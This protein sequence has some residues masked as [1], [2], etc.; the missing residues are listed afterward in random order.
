MSAL[1]PFNPQYGKS[2]SL[3][4]GTSSASV[5]LP[6]QGNAGGTKQ[7][8]ILNFGT[9]VVFVRIS[10]SRNGATP[11]ASGT[12]G[13]ADMP[14]GPNASVT[15]TKGTDDDTLSAIAGAAGNTIWVT[16]GEGW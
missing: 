2:V 1:Q 12:S 16:C 5:P 8:T 9:N 4:V 7:V 3:A 11:A 6:A 15:L 14:I 13:T 10:N